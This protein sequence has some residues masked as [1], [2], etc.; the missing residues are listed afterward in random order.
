MR[1]SIRSAESQAAQ[2][3]RQVPGKSR[4][5]FADGSPKTGLR[6]ASPAEARR[7]SGRPL[8]SSR[9]K[10]AH[11][12]TTAGS[13]HSSQPATQGT[14]KQC[15][16]RKRPQAPRSTASC[17]QMLNPYEKQVSP[18]NLTGNPT[19]DPFLTNGTICSHT[20]HL[21]L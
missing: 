2:G 17:Q 9:R 10:H 11:S 3:I 8:G 16:S 14:P 15:F 6:N 18:P 1:T 5:R 21:A 4:R 12:R 20:K 13:S 19:G 7:P